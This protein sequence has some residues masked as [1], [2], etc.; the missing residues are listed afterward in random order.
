MRLIPDFGSGPDRFRWNIV[1]SISGEGQK[2]S[3]PRKALTLINKITTWDRSTK[4]G[5]D[6]TLTCAAFQVRPGITS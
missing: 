1:T 2:G 6:P 3:E 5:S 4:S